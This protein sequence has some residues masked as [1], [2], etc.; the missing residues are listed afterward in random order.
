MKSDYYRDKYLLR[1]AKLEDEGFNNS[2]KA[3]KIAKKFLRS[4]KN[5]DSGY[6]WDFLRFLRDD[7]GDS[8]SVK[9]KHQ[10]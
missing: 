6:Y 10:G 3:K 1:L 4:K 8:V 7:L 5:I 9:K 2:K